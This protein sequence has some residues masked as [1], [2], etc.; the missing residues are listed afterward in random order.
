MKQYSIVQRLIFPRRILILPL[1]LIAVLSTEQVLASRKALVIGNS[2]YTHLPSL[3]NPGRDAQLIHRVLSATSFSVTMR[4]D[5]NSNDLKATLSAFCNSLSP[6]DVAVVYYSGHG[7]Q[8]NDESR[9]LPVDYDPQKVKFDYEIND[10]TLSLEDILGALG[11]AQAK[12]KIVILDACRDLL[13]F[14]PANRRGTEA[15]GLA[16]VHTPD[17]ETL[18]CYSTKAG[19]AAVDNSSYAPILAEEIVRPGKDIDAVMREVTRR[20]KNATN[21]HQLPWTYG[22]LT[23]D[24]YFSAVPNSNP[25]EASPVVATP[26]PTQPSLTTS[27]PPNLQDFVKASLHHYVS[28]DATEWAADFAPDVNYCY[29]KGSGGA[30]R[31]Y[32]EQDRAKLLTSYPVRHY[33][34]SGLTIQTDPSGQSAN[35]R[36]MYRYTYSGK[37]TASGTSRVNLTVQLVDGAWSITDFYETVQRN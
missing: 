28:N 33:E 9:L 19:T 16:D 35:V 25:P 2:Q 12:P 8:F 36:Y 6:D 32:V 23:E 14:I 27:A 7:F 22:N 37:K 34:F 15:A 20:V 26:S 11:K 30:N 4:E 10:N 21:G 13:P 17:D 1:V 5:L 18:V 3:A 31:S 24:F 29:Y